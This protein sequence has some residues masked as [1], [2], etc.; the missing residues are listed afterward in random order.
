MRGE[1]PSWAEDHVLVDSPDHRYTAQLGFIAHFPAYTTV[2]KDDGVTWWFRQGEKPR[3]L[4]LTRDPKNRAVRVTGDLGIARW[5]MRHD[6][7]PLPDRGQIRDLPAPH[8]QLFEQFGGIR[9][10]VFANPFEGM[11]WAI[12]GQQIT[13]GFA[14]QLK[15]AIAQRY[16]T[17]VVD[18]GN[19]CAVFPTASV[20]SRASIDELRQLKLSRQKAETLVWVAQALESGHWD[21][22]RWHALETRNVYEEL[23][24]VKGIGPWTAEYCLLRVF[25]HPDILPAGDVALRRA[26]AHITNTS[27]VSETDLR[28]VSEFWQGVRSDFAFWLW[29]YSFQQRHGRETK[30]SLDAFS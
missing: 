28:Q 4:R 29:L 7:R 24:S 19:E 15:N 1:P 17:K 9:P 30:V 16:G 3:S 26:W 12:L 20:M 14:A 2:E 8:R 13:V 10:I 23:L 6:A 25:G 11:A 5:V 18:G 22:G 27:M 21:V